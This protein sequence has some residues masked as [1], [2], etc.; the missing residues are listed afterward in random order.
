MLIKY[1]YKSTSNNLQNK[2][3]K[4]ELEQIVIDLSTTNKSL[5]A[6]NS[7]LKEEGRKYRELFI[8]I[9]RI[10]NESADKML[11]KCRIEVR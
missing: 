1:R 4:N 11:E 6:V 3:T 7:E 2:M 10:W 8:E 5:A 9:T